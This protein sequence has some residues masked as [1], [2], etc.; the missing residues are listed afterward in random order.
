MW[1]SRKSSFK[2]QFC[3]CCIYFLEINNCPFVHVYMHFVSRCIFQGLLSEM[4]ERYRDTHGRIVYN[5]DNYSWRKCCVH[6]EV[7]GVSTA[8]TRCVWLFLQTYVHE[9]FGWQLGL[10][11][12]EFRLQWSEL[13]LCCICVYFICTQWLYMNMS[14]RENLST[15]INTAAITILFANNLPLN[16]FFFMCI[17][18]SYSIHRIVICCLYLWLRYD[19]AWPVLFFC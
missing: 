13:N 1:F 14:S 18:F 2:C 12:L 5:A 7:L 3:I 19:F 6:P 4:E 9:V 16:N 15:D 11:F 17:G 10:S 8:Q